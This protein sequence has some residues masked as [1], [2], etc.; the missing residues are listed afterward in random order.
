MSL[1]DSVMMLVALRV[2]GGQQLDL[3]RLGLRG[4]DLLLRFRVG[5]NERLL[6]LRAGLDEVLLGDLLGLDGGDVLFREVP[7]DDVQIVNVDAVL[8]ELGVQA[9]VELDAHVHA[10]AYELLRGVLER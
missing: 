4:D 1:S 7:V 3:V 6:L 9:F 5:N 8:V 2:R 10:V